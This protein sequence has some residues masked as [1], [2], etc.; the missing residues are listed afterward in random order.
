MRWEKVKHSKLVFAS[1]ITP[2]RYS[3]YNVQYFAVLVSEITGSF[4]L[5]FG[6]LLH[7]GLQAIQFNFFPTHRTLWDDRKFSPSHSVSD[8]WTKS[9]MSFL[10][11]QHT[12][13]QH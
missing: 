1:V 10:D 11:A 5:S 3:V 13:V 9:T 7:F 8:W 4:N 6:L 12:G 2:C